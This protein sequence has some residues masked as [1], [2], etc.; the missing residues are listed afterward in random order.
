M[1][2]WA[3]LDI[4]QWLV[5]FMKMGD[6][7]HVYQEEEEGLGV[8]LIGLTPPHLCVSA[9]GQDLEFQHVV[10]CSQLYSVG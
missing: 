7:Q 4:D 10:V 8:P 2:V 9:L 5:L 1:N 3:F 6:G